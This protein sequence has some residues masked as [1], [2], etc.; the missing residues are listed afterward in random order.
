MVRHTLM[1]R[2]VKSGTVV[3]PECE[4]S[5]GDRV[6]PG[7]WRFGDGPNP[8]VVQNYVMT[9]EMGRWLKSSSGLTV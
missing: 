4:V 9:C 5:V 6:K 7:P 2:H 8:D 3:F 1:L